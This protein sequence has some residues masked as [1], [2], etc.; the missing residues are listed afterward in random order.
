MPLVWHKTRVGMGGRRRIRTAVRTKIL[1]ARSSE[2]RL[3]LLGST[4]SKTRMLPSRSR[5]ARSAAGHISSQ[6]PTTLPVPFSA[7]PADSA[8]C[9]A[10]SSCVTYDDGQLTPI[11]TLL[12][13]AVMH[14]AYACESDAAS[15]EYNRS[16]CSA[17]DVCGAGKARV[18][19]AP[20]A[21]VPFDGAPNRASR[22]SSACWSGRKLGR[23]AVCVDAHFPRLPCAAAPSPNF[24]P[25]PPNAGLPL[26]RPP[27]PRNAGTL[28]RA[29]CRSASSW[30]SSSSCL[31]ALAAGWPAALCAC[32]GEGH[33]AQ[34]AADRLWQ[35]FQSCE[36]TCWPQAANSSRVFAAHSLAGLTSTVACQLP[37]TGC[38]LAT[39]CWPFDALPRPKPVA[40]GALSPPDMY[41]GFCS[42]SMHMHQAQCKERQH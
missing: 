4:R 33:A 11:F 16:G 29:R 5:S 23:L 10:Y 30:A 2:L 22:L 25:P 36:G 20:S 27:P 32:N 1:T 18:A 41:C 13:A 34:Q 38:V 14:A 8:R 19:S 40:A 12:N 9:R 42:P 3:G 7:V 6:V 39:V 24:A 15:I 21:S 31:A 26:L 35:H 17:P 28:A 37:N